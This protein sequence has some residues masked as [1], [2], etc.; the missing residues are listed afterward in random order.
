MSGDTESDSFN[1]DKYLP[2][3]D[4]ILSVANLEEVTIKRI[5]NAL[6]ELF[7]IDLSPTKKQVNDLIMERYHDLIDKRAKQEELD[8]EE[9]EKQDA[10]LAAKLS[11]EENKRSTK[12][13][14]PKTRKSRPLSEKQINN[15]PFNREMVLSNELFNVIGTYKASR[16]QVVKLLW[17]YIKDNNLQNP[18]D[19]RQINC[20]DKL[21]NLFKK[22]TVGAFEMNKILSKHI[23][24]PDEVVPTSYDEST[25]TDSTNIE[26]EVEKIF[27]DDD[28][29][30]DDDESSEEE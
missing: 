25:K 2:T 16:P 20:D 14:S 10:L 18:S 11:R 6:Q 26:Q 24:K 29:D 17:A 1:P 23:F 15:N 21:T 12:R 9:M 30:D 22:S 7:G 5:R 4:A 19:K 8:K 28:D 13:S 3:I 27:N